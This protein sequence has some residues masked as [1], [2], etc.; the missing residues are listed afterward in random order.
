M[1]ELVHGLLPMLHAAASYYSS[2]SD[3]NNGGEF[4]LL[5]AG[6][7]SAFALYWAIFR[8]YRNTDKTNQFERET[9]VEAKPVQGYDKKVDEVHGTR[10]RQVDGDNV[11]NFRLRVQRVPSDPQPTGPTTT[12]QPQHPTEPAAQP[13]AAAAAPVPLPDQTS[14]P[15]VSPTPGTPAP[16][17]PTDPTPPPWVTAEAPQPPPPPAE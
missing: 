15:D 10:N 17:A 4:A 5:A 9:R 11:S 13:S 6:P 3:S 8:Y 1:I 16:T 14:S 7:V 12:L 2:N